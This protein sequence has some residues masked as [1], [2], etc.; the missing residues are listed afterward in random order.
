MTV[1]RRLG[2]RDGSIHTVSATA[3][4]TKTNGQTARDPGGDSNGTGITVP[5]S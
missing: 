1:P 2:G 4:D 5:K 3:P